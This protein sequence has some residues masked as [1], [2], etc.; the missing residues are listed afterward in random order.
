M[1]RIDV[2]A[3]EWVRGRQTG[4]GRYL[5]T[6]LRRAGETRP[7]WQWTLYLQADGEQ[8]LE[9]ERIEYVELPGGPTPLVDQIHIPRRLRRNPPDLFFSPYQKGPWS[10]PCHVI[11]VVHDMHP[12][13]LPPRW[14]GLHGPGRRWFYWYT[15]RSVK[16][17]ARV[18][19]VSRA[20][21]RDI[22][23]YLHIP[24]EKMTVI[25]ESVDPV[26]GE[27]RRSLE[28]LNQLELRGPY[29]LAVGHLRP[30][31]NQ[32]TLLK[33]WAR[34]EERPED[35][36]LVVVGSGPDRERLR[37]VA[38]EQRVEERTVWIDHAG[39]EM[40]SA[41][42]QEATAL[43]QPSIIEGFGLPVLEAMAS[44]TPVVVSS[45]GS[46]PEVVADAAP[47]VAPQDVDGWA[48]EM[49]RMLR[50][51]GY[52]DSWKGRAIER[53]GAFA[54]EKTTDRLLDLIADVGQARPA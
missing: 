35:A 15:R 31:K 11:V 22:E 51:P 39:D 29:L 9:S 18:V 6:M 46:L 43:L 49:S 53:A 25:H 40:L 16:K 8:R 21:A 3:R 32:E 38:E 44:G 4:I 24:K 45:G 10:A 5:E 48:V 19:T 33:A 17:A 27:S 20:S 34:V 12:L 42:Y 7:Q 41:L 50:D 1:M 54:P 13:V 26:I 30:H 37:A 36:R 28:I 52:R 14:G 2:D 47:V 23:E